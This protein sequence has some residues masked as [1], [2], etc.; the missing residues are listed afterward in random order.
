MQVFWQTVVDIKEAVNTNNWNL[1]STAVVYFSSSSP[2]KRLLSSAGSDCPGK[3]NFQL[4]LGRS[5]S[6][7]RTVIIDF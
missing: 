2:A 7:Q 6:Q 1:N 4:T 5:I 3:K